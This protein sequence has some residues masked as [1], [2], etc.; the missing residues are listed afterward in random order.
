MPAERD[1]A[2]LPM[3]A[4]DGHSLEET[5]CRHLLQAFALSQDVHEPEV[6]NDGGRGG[7]GDG[8]GGG[9]DGAG[10]GGGATAVFV[11]MS[12]LVSELD[13]ITEPGAQ[14]W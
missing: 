9:G 6:D 5:S 1:C 8:A 13:C 10:G 14:R 11:I 4:L 7:G 3:F 12:V 2:Q